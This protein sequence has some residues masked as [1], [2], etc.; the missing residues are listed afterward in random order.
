MGV[1]SVVVTDLDDG[2]LAL[3]KKAGADHIVNV[4]YDSIY[5]LKV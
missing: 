1:S 5:S 4:R 3:A 2:R